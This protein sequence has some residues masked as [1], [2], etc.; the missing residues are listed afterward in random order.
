MVQE[1]YLTLNLQRLRPFEEWC[2]G[3]KD[4]SFAL[5]KGGQGQY[6]MGSG[7]WQLA[8][9][10]LLA[11]NPGSYGKLTAHN[12]ELTY[13]EFASPLEHLLLLCSAGEMQML[14]AVRENIRNPRIYSAST[15]LA[16]QCYVLAESAPAP[17]GID[18]RSHVLR[19]IVAVLGQEFLN[20]SANR[21][22]AWRGQNNLN[23]VC[24]ELSATELLTLSIDELANKFRCSR[25]HLSR[26]FRQQFGSSVA[27]LR[28]ELRL[29]K[30]AAL[31]RDPCAKVFIVA[32][33]CGFHHTGL[34]N[35]C[36]KRR[37]GQPPGQWQKSIFAEAGA[38]GSGPLPTAPAISGK[39][40]KVNKKANTLEEK[41]FPIFREMHSDDIKTLPVP[42]PA[43]Y[44]AMT[45]CAQSSR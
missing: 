5:I 1:H 35:H 36:F 23:R 21:R 4:L 43:R 27:E 6:E 40:S 2:P 33:Q 3:D 14:Q 31:L 10:D 13:W 28:M 20:A 39:S 11:L 24:E 22:M 15:P 45:P 17:G 44:R 37:F 41:S 9:G 8:S 30:A 19:M 26:L 38:S 25:R 34:F 18:H 32:E 42:P 16:R 12:G 29:L 7:V